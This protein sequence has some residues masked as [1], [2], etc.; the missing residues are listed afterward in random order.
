MRVFIF[1]AV[2]I[3]LV[4]CTQHEPKVYDLNAPIKNLAVKVN[5]TRQVELDSICE[6]D[7]HILGTG[8]S[9]QY[10]EKQWYW[11]NDSITYL[12]TRRE[13]Y[14]DWTCERCGRVIRE[15]VDPDTVIVWT[16]K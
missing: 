2:V 5:T 16:K 12:I 4:R 8:M 3:F 7:G 9:N 1:L 11:G 14:V 15:Y 6:V 10:Q 13:S